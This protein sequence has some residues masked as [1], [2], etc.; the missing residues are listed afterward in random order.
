[1]PFERW[2]VIAVQVLATNL[3]IT[4]LIICKYPS[5]LVKFTHLWAFSSGLRQCCWT[6]P[7]MV[8]L[9]AVSAEDKTTADLS[10]T[11]HPPAVIRWDKPRPTPRWG[12]HESPA[13]QQA[14]LSTMLE[15]PLI[16]RHKHIWHES[17]EGAIN[18]KKLLSHWFKYFTHFLC[19]QKNRYPT[20]CSPRIR[21]WWTSLM[22]ELMQPARHNKR[23]LML[24]P[25]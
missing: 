4:P 23:H 12:T 19:L 20:W 16:L 1:M 21:K 8:A 24:S 25:T 11:F 17:G 9:P 18:D 10:V 14:F 2:N 6:P 15:V 13:P 7:L 22:R 5:W 3:H